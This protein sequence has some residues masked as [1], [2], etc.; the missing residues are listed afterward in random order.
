MAFKRWILKDPARVRSTGT[1]G[2]LLVTALALSAPGIAR[3][4]WPLFGRDLGNSRSAG[5]DGPS[6]T[7]VKTLQRAWSFNSSN[8]D[9]T[10][11]PVVAGGTLVAG[12]NL[13]SVF[14]LDAASGKLLWSHDV[15]QPINGSA[16]ID[17]NAPGGPTAFVPVAELGGPRLLALSLASGSIRWDTVLTSQPGSDVYASPVFWHGI[18]YMGTSGPAND[19]STARGSVVA[20]DE[21][22]GKPRWQ[23]Y[24]VPPGYDGGGVWSTPSIDPTTGRLYVGTGNAYHAPAADTT[25]SIMALS[26]S[27]GQVLGHFQATPSDV[28]QLSHPTNGPDYD[29]GASA[30][31]FA[32]SHGRALVGEGQKSGIY[33]ALDRA[34]LAPVWTATVGPGSQADGGIG[35]TASDGNTIYGSDSI[36]S[37]VFALSRDGATR[38]N[39]FDSGTL[40]IS[41]VAIGNGIIYS[42]TSD[43][44]LV[45]RDASTGAVLNSMPLGAPTFGGMSLV[46]HA[47]YV[48]VGTGP[49]SPVVPLPSS[50][51]QQGDGNGSI[52]AFGD[53]SAAASA[54]QFSLRF[55]SHTPRTSTGAELRAVVHRGSPN[56]KPS[57]LRSEVLDL[58]SGAR[59]DGSAVPAC[60][61]TDQQIQLQ[62]PSACPAAT[63]VGSGTI[64]VAIG[65]PL[66][67]ENADVAIFNWGQGTIEV[68]TPPGSNTTLAIDRGN[69]TGPG[70]LTNHPP[71]G[72]GGP[73]DFE[74]SVSAADLTYLDRHGFITTPPSCPRSR[75]WTSHI[76]YGTADGRTYHASS[77]TPCAQAAGSH[78]SGRP[79]IRVVLHP[80]RIAANT[81]ARV[82]V[83]L[84]SR[85]PRCI[86]G[87]HVRVGR[88]GAASSRRGRAVLTLPRMRPGRYRVIATKRGCRA[89]SARL[90]VL[91]R[92]R[93]VSAPSFTG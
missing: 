90:T 29:F 39:S 77:T 46:G 87:A 45:A 24:I 78:S 60:H 92:A 84:G 30:N 4:D 64:Q 47:V 70:Q 37:Q 80:A 72:P 67:P 48:A 56:E 66:D 81:A 63:K 3:A 74:T 83:S 34:T 17:L 1:R 16:A 13:G 88:V 85:A 42:A 2:L 91:R 51:T 36:D 53:T 11:T 61:A 38:W 21:A 8:G 32:D 12:T 40:H 44:L 75:V 54:G 71:K 41:P 59:F 35:S 20:L 62:G 25:D 79:G 55:S 82:R 68:L 19:E 89:G 27:T 93:R 57:P 9:F 52:V 49:P 28:W 65:S 23:T 5:S 50:S 73:P 18:I 10:G 69:F 58:P 22:T 15:G 76:T 86:A 33:W 7:E 31:L 43:G 26:A 14:A 6:A